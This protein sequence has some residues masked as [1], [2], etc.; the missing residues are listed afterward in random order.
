MMEKALK[1]SVNKRPQLPFTVT[2]KNQICDMYENLLKTK[3]SASCNEISK[4]VASSFGV[5][6]VSV[7]RLVKEKKSGVL[8]SPK[9]EKHR[10][11]IVDKTNEDTKR[12]IREIIQQ[13]HKRKEDPTLDN[14]MIAIN[15][16]GTL[17]QFKRSSLHKLLK[18]IGHFGHSKS[19]TNSLAGKDD[20]LNIGIQ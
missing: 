13:F 11:T 15:R 1:S 4:I 5:H 3:P 6:W 12:A 17:G 20:A 18:S 8:R 9:T 2:E 19:R 14:I 16:D 7:H 10:L